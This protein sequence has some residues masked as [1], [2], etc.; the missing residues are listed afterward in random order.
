[1]IGFIGASLSLFI[2]F[3]SSAAPIPLYEHFAQTLNLSK[4]DLAMT[5]V[6]Y[7]AG[8]II[9]LLFFARISNYWGRK[10]A[11]YLILV[12]GMLGCSAFIFADSELLILLGRFI[13]G[14]ASGLASST[15]MAFI[16]DN[17][18]KSMPNIGVSITSSGPNLGLIVGAVITGVFMEFLASGTFF[19]F[20]L[21]ITILAICFI[22]IFFS[23]ETISP[24]AGILHSFKPKIHL[25]NNV[26][27]L[28]L[29]AGC[30]SFASWSFGGFYQSY[31]AT[32][33]TQIFQLNDT[34]IASLVFV[35][36]IGPIALG[37][38]LAKNYDGFKAQAY[39]MSFYIISLIALYLS[40]FSQSLYLY[41]AINII[42]GFFSG[43]MFAGSLKTILSITDI[44]DRADVLSAIYVISY[45]GAAIPNLIISQIAYMFD[46]TQLVFG[47]VV[48]AIISYAVLLLSRRKLNLSTDKSLS[49]N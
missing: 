8:T 11:I 2:L 47:Y 13:Q 32:I 6:L 49:Q 29:P 30:T 3:A 20:E 1:M 34:F 5:S 19:I 7:F 37:A 27:P 21:L 35:S 41:L 45:G 22:L 46:L 23:R 31:S 25:P 26:K 18:P 38:M 16:L 15:V 28:L 14:I 43:L 48:L 42:A 36:F 4:G 10:K 40:L 39:G 9:A 44:H 17:E 33:A 24:K 12:L